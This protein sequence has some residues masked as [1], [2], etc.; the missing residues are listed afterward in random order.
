[1][2]YTFILKRPSGWTAGGV[3]GRPAPGTGVPVLHLRRQRGEGGVVLDP[4]S[5]GLL[6]P[7]PPGRSTPRFSLTVHFHTVGLLLNNLLSGLPLRFIVL[8]LRLASVWLY[9]L[10]CDPGWKP[11]SPLSPKYKLCECRSATQKHSRVLKAK[12]EDFILNGWFYQTLFIH[13]F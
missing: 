8:L 12:K 11:V 10:Q 5:G 7:L 4:G 6:S 1:M 3:P 2:L 13:R 9:V